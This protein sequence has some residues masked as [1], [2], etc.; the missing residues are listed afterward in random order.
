MPHYIA[1]I[2]KDEN[3]AY[4]VSFPDLPGCF[5]AADAEADIIPNA[6]E[7]LEL[8]F[9]DASDRPAPTGIEQLRTDPDVAADLAAGA[10][11]IAVPWRF[12]AGKSQRINIT[13]DK[14]LLELI[15]EEAARRKMTRSALL[16][17]AAER[18]IAE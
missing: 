18:E 14:G 6:M 13:L 1:V 16:A 2:H 3:S 4:G 12:N 5:S 8:W 9:E 10:Y 15:D 17:Q 7:A 11:L